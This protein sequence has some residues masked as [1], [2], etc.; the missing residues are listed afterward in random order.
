MRERKL[1][2][3]RKQK[4][5]ASVAVF[6]Q[7]EQMTDFI[8]A[9]TV[10]IYWSMSSELPTHS[11][12][13]KWSKKKTI[14]L[15]SVKGNGLRMKKFVS[16]DVLVEGETKTKEPK[17]ENYT[18]KVDLA[19]IP[20]IAFDKKKN[21]LGRGKGYYDRFLSKKE[22]PKYGVCFHFQLLKKV[23]TSR[24]DVKMDKIITPK[25]IIE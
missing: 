12:I 18:G 4:E 25:R 11:F 13:E 2:I 8:N 24:K 16:A 21:R 6:S 3:T 23:P 1:A 15:P 7:L 14:L 5:N 9:E 22:I 19:V 17:T 10:L 20:G